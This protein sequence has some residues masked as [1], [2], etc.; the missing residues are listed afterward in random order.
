[1]VLHMLKA[2]WV[3]E[4]RR[5]FYQRALGRIFLGSSMGMVW[6]CTLSAFF[7]GDG[8]SMFSFISLFVQDTRHAFAVFR[9][10]HMQAQPWERD[11][12]CFYERRMQAARGTKRDEDNGMQF[13]SPSHTCRGQ[14][15]VSFQ[16]SPG[17]MILSSEGTLCKSKPH[18]RVEADEAKGFSFFNL[19]FSSAVLEVSTQ[20]YCKSHVI[21]YPTLYSVAF[22]WSLRHSLLSSETKALDCFWQWQVSVVFI[23]QRRHMT[24]D[25]RTVNKTKM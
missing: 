21:K 9:A 15:D 5:A 10:F 2:P 20:K 22:V 25:L 11:R 19:L 17:V 13:N 6:V 3:S 4:R 8:M 12:T 23:T 24:P 18:H 7:Y 16:F 14:R 1:M